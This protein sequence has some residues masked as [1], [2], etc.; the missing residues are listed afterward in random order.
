MPQ[1]HPVKWLCVTMGIYTCP[2]CRPSMGSVR[3][4]YIKR[5]AIELLHK[6]PERFTADF[7]HN[8]HMVGELTDVVSIT[9]RNRIGGYLT[10]YRRRFES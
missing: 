3:P 2:R 8:T 7:R 4:T 1:H 10:R 6:H 5:V 9:M